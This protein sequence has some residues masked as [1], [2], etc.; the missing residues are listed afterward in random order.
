MSAFGLS[1]CWFRFF[2]F[3]QH[4][5]I[6]NDNIPFTRYRWFQRCQG[7]AITKHLYFLHLFDRKI[8]QGTYV[9][10]V[11]VTHSV[12]K[13]AWVIDEK[14]K[15]DCITP[16]VSVHS[17]WVQM[18]CRPLWL[19]SWLASS[20]W[21]LLPSPWWWAHHLAWSS[22]SPTEHNWYYTPDVRLRLW[23]SSLSLASTWSGVVFVLV[24]PHILWFV[25]YS[26]AFVPTVCIT[27]HG[28]VHGVI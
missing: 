21:S 2:A 4:N 17:V 24:V 23:C 1:F 16:G 9:S 7:A 13:T 25:L 8:I 22:A 10:N 6:T 27:R 11:C 28:L 12:A 26:V 15:T 19:S 14:L 20:P 18:E 3:L 5:M